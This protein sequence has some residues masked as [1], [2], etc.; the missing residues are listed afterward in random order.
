M[1]VNMPVGDNALEG[2]SKK[3]R[4]AQEQAGEQEPDQTRQDHGCSSDRQPRSAVS[5]SARHSHVGSQA[6]GSRPV[7]DSTDNSGKNR[8]RD[9]AAA[10]RVFCVE[11]H[12]A[13]IRVTRWLIRATPRQ[14]R[15][16]TRRAACFGISAWRSMIARKTKRLLQISRRAS[17]AS[18]A[19]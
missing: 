14:A 16:A 1:A 3:A 4:A 19:S 12:R 7:L 2:R 9:A 10:R 5:A 15:C 11:A 13:R 17:S 6:L 8:T 18:F